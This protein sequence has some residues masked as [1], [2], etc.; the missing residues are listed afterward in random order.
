MT[1]HLALI[2]TFYKESVFA[3]IEAVELIFQECM[4]QHLS[5]SYISNFQGMHV[6]ASIYILYF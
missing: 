4:F 1:W 6:S 3:P 5:I 2:Q